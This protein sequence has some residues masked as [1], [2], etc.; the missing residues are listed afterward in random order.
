MA[1]LRLPTCALAIVVA[2][3]LQ[4]RGLAAE[5][6]FVLTPDDLVTMVDEFNASL[7]AQSASL[8]RAVT[9]RQGA[10]TLA[11]MRCPSLAAEPAR[12]LTRVRVLDGPAR[13]SL[14]TRRPRLAQ[15]LAAMGGAAWG[16]PATPL[17]HQPLWIVDP[18]VAGAAAFMSAGFSN[19]DQTGALAYTAAGDRS[20]NFVVKV[21]DL[22]EPALHP[23]T[24]PT[25][26]VLAI[27]TEVP[28][29]RPHRRPKRLKRDECYLLGAAYSADPQILSD[30]VRAAPLDSDLRNHLL[31]IV[32]AGQHRLVHG[33]TAAA[34][35][36]LKR[37]A[38]EAALRSLGE[39]SPEMAE[40]MAL[41]TIDAIEA[42]GL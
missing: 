22:V 13:A 29:D 25:E 8:E 31:R 20:P 27:T 32:T 39:I 15:V 38:T 30:L 6:T 40:A 17:T 16:P 9:L 35:A 11:G 37:F 2:L 33:E 26:L 19:A 1:V 14:L 34:T 3:A 42:M 4:G 41:R 5:R 24:A 10:V 18:A 28:P 36:F 12:M 23:L 21:N 7:I